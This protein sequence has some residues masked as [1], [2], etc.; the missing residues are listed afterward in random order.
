VNGR[1]IAVFGNDGQAL[2]DIAARDRAV[3]ERLQ[4][5]EAEKIAPGID[6]F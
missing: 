3:A 5:D 6:S 1:A 2:A 4:I